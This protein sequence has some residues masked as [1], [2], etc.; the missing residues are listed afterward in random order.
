MA[1][2][3]LNL[4]DSLYADVSEMAERLDLMIQRGDQVSE[5]VMPAL[6]RLRDPPVPERVRPSRSGGEDSE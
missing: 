6:E 1:K 3:N 5:L 2:F 4:S